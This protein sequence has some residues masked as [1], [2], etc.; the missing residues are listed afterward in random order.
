VAEARAAD[1][2]RIAGLRGDLAD[3]LDEAKGVPLPLVLRLHQLS[4]RLGALVE[5]LRP[6]RGRADVDREHA[7]HTGTVAAVFR[8]GNV[9][10][11][12]GIKVR[13]EPLWAV[14]NQV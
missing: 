6:R 13:T 2:V 11:G 10:A 1:C 5:E 9:A 3:E 12:L 7:R 14:K 8:R 4:H